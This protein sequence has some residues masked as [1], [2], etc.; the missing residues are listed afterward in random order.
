[1]GWGTGDAAD[2]PLPARLAVSAVAGQ[3]RGQPRPL[4][5]GAGCT[6]F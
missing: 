5:C 1:M 6:I 3:R 4:P 2:W